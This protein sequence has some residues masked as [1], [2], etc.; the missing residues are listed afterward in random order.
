LG[1]ISSIDKDLLL[2]ALI[3]CGPD[4]LAKGLK[5][6]LATYLLGGAAMI[7]FDDGFTAANN[8]LNSIKQEFGFSIPSLHLYRL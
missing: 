5:E 3:N 8:F 4:G 2:F 6:D 7:M 1:G